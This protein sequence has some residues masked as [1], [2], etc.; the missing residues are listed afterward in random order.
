MKYILLILA[1]FSG[2]CFASNEAPEENKSLRILSWS[3]II[4]PEVISDFEKEHEISIEVTAYNNVK[5]RDDFLSNELVE[6]YDLIITSNTGFHEL[7]E[8]NYIEPIDISL[9]KNYQNLDISILNKVN[10]VEHSIPLTYTSMGIAYRKDK[11]KNPPKDWQEYIEF[12]IK[13]PG[14]ALIPKNPYD[15]FSIMYLAKLES[16]VDITVANLFDA[17][18]TLNQL[19]D[20]IHSFHFSFDHPSEPLY[21]AE[22]WIGVTYNFDA[23]DLIDKNPNIGFYYPEKGTRIWVDSISIVKSSKMK[24]ES[25]EFIDEILSIESGIKNFK[26]NGYSSSNAFYGQEKELAEIN[27]DN[28]LLLPEKSVQKFTFHKYDSFISDKEYYFYTR[29]MNK[30][31][32]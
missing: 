15:V 22:A 8:N 25:Y 19:S 21:S 11:I 24:E 4:S 27:K 17:A 2:L 16:M 30:D 1:L 26:Y 14:K 7:I 29:I 18:E 13:N 5:M 31:E 20:N 28:K 6:G 10:Y 23:L 12:I 32:E 9:I 3:G